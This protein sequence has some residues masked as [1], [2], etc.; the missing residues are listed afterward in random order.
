[1]N[2]WKN[3]VTVAMNEK[4]DQVLQERADKCPFSAKYTQVWR[5]GDTR[6]ISVKSKIWPYSKTCLIPP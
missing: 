4:F 2:D 5:H 1:M 3:Y 6:P